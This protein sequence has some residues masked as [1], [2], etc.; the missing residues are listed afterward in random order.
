M[1]DNRERHEEKLPLFVFV[2]AGG[3]RESLDGFDLLNVYG[4]PSVVIDDIDVDGAVVDTSTPSSRPRLTPFRDHLDGARGQRRRTRQRGRSRRPQHLPA[5]SFWE[6]IPGRTSTPPAEPATTRRGVGTPRSSRAR[7]VLPVL[8][9]QTRTHHRPR[10][11][12]RRGRRGGLAGHSAEQFREQV[13]EEVSTARANLDHR[14][15]DGVDIAVLDTDA[16]LTSTSSRRSRS[17][18][19]NSTGTSATRVTPCSASQRT[20]CTSVPTVIW[21]CTGLSTRSASEFP[22][23]ASRHGASATGPS[24][25][26]WRAPGCPRRHAR[27]AGRRTVT[28]QTFSPC[29]QSDR[30]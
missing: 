14:T 6:D 11:R 2:A 20:R 25:I 22:K 4:A 19:T 9:G 26:G 17:C 5:V 28:Q 30:A 24:A 23:A 10:V 29:R 3:T 21:T 1:L 16:S 7:S 27:R 13:D 12:R 15:V 18:S 8:R